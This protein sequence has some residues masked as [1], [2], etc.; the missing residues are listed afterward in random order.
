MDSLKTKKQLERLAGLQYGPPLHLIAK[1]KAKLPSK[2]FYH[3]SNKSVA[4]PWIVDV[5]TP[6]TAKKYGRKSFVVRRLN[7]I[8]IKS[9]KDELFAAE[10]FLCPCDTSFLMKL[11][12]V[13][14]REVLKK[15]NPIDHLKGK[16]V[17]LRKRERHIYKKL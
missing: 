8:D 4:G 1:R 16:E 11:V 3:V 15:I 13:H 7:N 17:Y 12:C 6:Q 14:I 9:T 2:T 10:N 5:L